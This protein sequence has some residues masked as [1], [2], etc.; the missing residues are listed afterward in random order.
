MANDQ[1]HRMQGEVF[2]VRG[3]RRPRPGA[4]SPVPLRTWWPTVRWGSQGGGAG[5]KSWGRGRGRG[6][7]S[8]AA[9][10]I[11][12]GG[13]RQRHRQ[14][15]AGSHKPG[16]VPVRSMAQQ[17]PPPCGHDKGCCCRRGSIIAVVAMGSILLGHGLV[18][19]VQQLPRGVGCVCC[20]RG[21]WLWLW[22]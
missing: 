6:F 18:P 12:P 7:C 8:A 10:A 3:R 20:G 19:G 5:Q 14:P 2:P 9:A 11:V 16:P 4:C 22:Q 21:R 1:H 15:D 13:I 17:P